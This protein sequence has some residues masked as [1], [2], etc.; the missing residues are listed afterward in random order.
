M[1]KLV[2]EKS[3]LN[4]YLAKEFLGSSHF[5][6]QSALAQLPKSATILDVGAAGGCM[7][8]F[9]LSCGFQDISAVEVD[10]E[11]RA[12]IGEIY[13]EVFDSL[14]GVVG[15]KYDCVLLLDVLEHVVDHKAFFQE[16]LNVVN[17]GGKVLLSV[18]NGVHW[19]VRLM[20]LFGFFEYF[21]R[22]PLDRTHVRFYTKRTLRRFLN[23]FSEVSS[24][25]FDVSIEP[26]ELVLP[27]WA[28]NNVV[29]ETLSRLRLA[30]ARFWPGLWAYQHLVLI[31][32]K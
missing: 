5:W 4:R 11:A 20:V 2:A 26:V 18:P 23:E 24:L 9:L 19:S 22:G 10:V 29:F 31:E 6:A 21:D 16:L 15:K 30:L 3:V 8:Q 28:S 25:K 12:K 14:N 27:D 32:K 13:K 1:N 17:D 7:G